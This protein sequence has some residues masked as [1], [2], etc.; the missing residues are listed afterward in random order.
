MS[1]RA[2]WRLEGLGFGRV[3]RYAA[4]KMDWF[5]AGLPREGR[6]A[7]IPRAG[8]AARRDVPT[9]APDEPVGA[10]RERARAAGLD[11]VV[12]VNP[13]R[14]VLGVLD[15]PALQ[16][17]PETRAEDVMNPGPVT[18]RP[19]TVLADLADQLQA[20]AT[21]LVTTVDGQLVGLLGHDHGTMPS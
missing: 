14:I 9:C 16:A 3:Y 8:D 11:Q 10:A 2:A 20:G 17:P 1:A 5:G 13:Q 7:P 6:L 18:H 21:V 12:V 4:G 15:P 19:D